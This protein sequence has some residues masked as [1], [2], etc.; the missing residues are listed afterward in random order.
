MAE[1]CTCGLCVLKAEAATPPPTKVP[2][3]LVY[4]EDLVAGMVMGVDTRTS[5]LGTTRSWSTVLEVRRHGGVMSA[6]VVDETGDQQPVVT[7]DFQ[8]LPVRVDA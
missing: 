7:N 8:L 3:R 4:A 5:L 6:I 1:R 2:Y